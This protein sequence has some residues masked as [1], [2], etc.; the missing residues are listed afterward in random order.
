MHALAPNILTTPS[1]ETIVAF[2]H[3][4]PLAKV[5]FPPFVDDFHLNMDLV[6]DRKAF[7]LIHFPHLSFDSPSGM[8]YETFVRLFYC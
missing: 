6:L 1:T 3:L 4:H 5:D 8:V 2:C 7:I